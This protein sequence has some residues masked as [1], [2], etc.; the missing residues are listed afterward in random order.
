MKKGKDQ[1]LKELK[2]KLEGIEKQ[3]ANKKY[4]TKHSSD[5]PSFELSAK[6]DLTV[7]I[8]KSS[9]DENS[10]EEIIEKYKKYE[11]PRLK[12]TKFKEV[13]NTK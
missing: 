1:M 10:D 12:N 11:D 8:P 7:N 9:Q 2:N 3:I 5:N 13:S 4:M 6:L